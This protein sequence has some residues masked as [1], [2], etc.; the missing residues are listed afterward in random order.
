VSYA[1]AIASSVLK[2]FAVNPKIP[3]KET[4]SLN[5]RSVKNA[6]KSISTTKLA[7]TTNR[8]SHQ[9]HFYSPVIVEIKTLLVEEP[10]SAYCIFFWYF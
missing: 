5:E 8:L 7:N 10:F 1:L 2:P 6:N 4:S 3:Q 9:I